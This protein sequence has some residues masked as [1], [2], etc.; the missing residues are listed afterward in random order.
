MNTVAEVVGCNDLQKT[1][2]LYQ[3]LH[4]GRGVT[5]QDEYVFNSP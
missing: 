5:S 4:L 3:L 2:L 1:G